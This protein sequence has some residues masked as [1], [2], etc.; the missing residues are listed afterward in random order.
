L[1]RSIRRNSSSC[2]SLIRWRPIRS[3]PAT[4]FRDETGADEGEVG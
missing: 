2:G 1:R 4:L 3:A